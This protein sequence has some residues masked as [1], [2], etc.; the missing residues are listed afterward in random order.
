MIKRSLFSKEE[1]LKRMRIEI[2][3]KLE[4]IITSLNSK[5]QSIAK[6]LMINTDVNF[7]ESKVGEESEIFYSEKSTGNIYHF[8]T[9][10]KKSCNCD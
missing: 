2:I 7:F 1:N 6:S 8:L 5:Q 9:A 10:V 3:E 4:Y